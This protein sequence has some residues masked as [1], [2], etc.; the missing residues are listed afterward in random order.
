MDLNLSELY[1]TANSFVDLSRNLLSNEKPEKAGGY[2]LIGLDDLSVKEILKIGE[3]D[4]KKIS[5]YVTI[6][7]EKAYRLYADWLRDST[8]VSSWQTRDPDMNRWGG[9]VLFGANA[10]NSDRNIISF[11]GLTEAADEAVSLALGKNLGFANSDYLERVAEISNNAVSR[12]L[13]EKLL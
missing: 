11:S 5:K 4:P 6:V 13:S 8:S 9:A 3:C 12:E 7:Q 10:G 2:L 1:D